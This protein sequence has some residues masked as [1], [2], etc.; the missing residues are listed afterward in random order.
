MKK[1]ALA[2]SFCAALAGTGQAQDR[3]RRIPPPPD[4]LPRLAL[5]AIEFIPLSND[6]LLSVVPW[7]S[8]PLM[9]LQLV[10]DAGEARSPENLPGLATCAANMFLRGTRLR[11]AS[12]IEELIDSVGGRMSLDVTQDHV[13]VTFQFL[14]DSLDAVLTLLAEMLVQPAFAER[15]LANVKFNVTYD[16]LEKEKDPE[17]VAHRHLLRVLF[18][19]HPYARF[20]FTRDVVRAWNLR[21]LQAFFDSTYRPNNAHLILVGNTNKDTATKKVS[22]RLFMW[23]P[24][25]GP[26][27]APPP[28]RLP[29]RDRVCFINVPGAK[30]CA[31][32]LGALFPPL[33]VD[34]RVDFNVI[35]EVLGGSTNARLFM[36]LRES[37]GFAYNA[38]SD[39]SH[40]RAGALFESRALVTPMVIHPAVQ[41]ALKILRAP[42]REPIAADEIEQAKA[43]LIGSFPLRLARL[44]DITVRAGLMRAAGWGNEAWDRYYEQTWLVG[45]ARVAAS[46]RIHLGS[47]FIVVIAGDAAVCAESLPDFELIEIYDARGRFQSTM[48]R[49]RKEPR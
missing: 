46:A 22:R 4:P 38:S 19:G 36:A 41:E 30:D 23:A 32:A 29:E 39:V 45:P 9:S 21:D 8:S 33:D 31:L 44:E 3:F 20:A 10:L 43:V 18:Q 40:F 12:D 34:D 37:K 49:D 25:G 24:R 5:P 42:L 27:P 48:T 6:L 14:E 17:F 7:N 1:A 11:S 16:L 47:P 2:L 13:F 26:A 28:P 35:N 15:E